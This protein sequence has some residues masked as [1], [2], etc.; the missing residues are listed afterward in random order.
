MSPKTYYQSLQVDSEASEEV[1]EVA[2]RRLARMYHPDLNKFPDAVRV[3]QELNEA[4]EVLRDANRRRDYDHYLARGSATPVSSV[5][6]TAPPYAGTD[7][8]AAHAA[9]SATSQASRRAAPLPSDFPVH[10]QKCGCSDASLRIAAFPY[11]VSLLLLT[12]RRAWGGLYCKK[13]RSS[14]MTRAKLI[15]L[16][17]GWWGIPFGPI[18]SLGCLFECSEGK[19]PPEA[20]GPYLAG[21]GVYFI[22]CGQFHDA[23]D[24]LEQ[25]LRYRYDEDVEE[26]LLSLPGKRSEEQVDRGEI[27]NLWQWVSILGV[28]AVIVFAAYYADPPTR[29]QR[30]TLL[31]VVTLAAISATSPT[32]SAT[33]QPTSPR[34]AVVIADT[35]NMREGPGKGFPVYAALNAGTVVEIV[36]QYDSCEWLKVNDDGK[37]GWIAGSDEQMNFATACETIPQ[38]IFRPLTGSLKASR[39]SNA[40]GELTIENGGTEDAVVVI[41]DN[42]K[43]IIGSA[44]IRASDKHTL[45]RIKDGDYIVWVM[46]GRGWDGARFTAGVSYGRFEDSI[47]FKTTDEGYVTWEITLQL[48]Y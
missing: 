43:E 18:Y 2:Y 12:F 35:L 13:C 27:N 3:M 15:T 39:A 25:S 38:G 6:S 16:L 20:N 45:R 1:I 29:R 14:E 7:S 37:I 30:S 9:S 28:F 48:Y 26:L 17:L 22:M 44:Y 31:P 32:L 10:C 36:G 5:A 21:L 41:T 42:A 34:T 23:R 47:D 4:Y 46:S 40:Y 24:A 33:P 8:R 11:V 19:T